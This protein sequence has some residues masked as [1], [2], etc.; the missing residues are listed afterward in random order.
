MLYIIEAAAGG[1]I[2]RSFQGM[3]QETVSALVAVNGNPFEFVSEEDFAAKV[4]EI[5][6]L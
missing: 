6:D 2:A 5:G 4:A 1:D 3:S